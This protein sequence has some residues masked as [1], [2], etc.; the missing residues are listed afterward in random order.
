MKIRSGGNIQLLELL[1]FTK[2]EIKMIQS[3]PISCTSRSDAIIWRGTAN[4]ILSVRSAYYIQQDLEEQSVAGTSNLGC[5]REVWRKLWALPVP[6]VEKH[7][8]WRA[9]HN[10]LP[11]RENLSKRKVI[12]DSLCPFCEQ[13]METCFHIL[14]Q[15][16]SARDVWSMGPIKIQKSFFSSPDFMQ[17]VEGIFGACT[18]EEM[19]QFVGLARRIWLRR[20]EVSTWGCFYTPT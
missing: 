10:S 13:D 17:I 19:V 3:I 1:M 7:F 2:E 11:T 5:K 12:M 18:E 14:W 6:N 16:P 4:G 9:C 8:I 15:C 20:N